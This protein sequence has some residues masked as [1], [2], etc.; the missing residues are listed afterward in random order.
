MGGRGW[1][2][3]VMYIISGESKTRC[4]MECRHDAGKPENPVLCFDEIL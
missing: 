2:R 3:D 1:W 4:G